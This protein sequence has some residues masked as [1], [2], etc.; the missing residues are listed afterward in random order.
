MGAEEALVRVG[1][2]EKPGARGQA[3][4]R[5]VRGEQKA[6]LDFRRSTCNPTRMSTK[7]IALESGVYDRLARHKRQSE[8]FSKVI[9]RLLSRVASAHTAADVLARLDERPPLAESDAAT[10]AHVV[11][12]SRET[13]AWPFHDLS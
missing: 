3:G 9:D 13:E 5:E 6:Q 10:M 12:E 4:E 2:R 1:R 8:S 7:T 11:R